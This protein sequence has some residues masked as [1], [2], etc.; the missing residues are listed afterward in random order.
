MPT[1]SIP[2]AV[3]AK[4]RCPFGLL[5]AVFC[6]LWASAFSVAKLAIAD[7]PPLL[8][9]TARF[10]LAGLVMLGAAAAYGLPLRQA[11]RDLFLFAALGVANQA[12]YL[13]LGYI[14]MR[15]MSSGLAALIISA[16]P[17]LAALGAALFLGERMSWQKVVGLLAGV[18]GV[19][20]V[21][22]NRLAGG[23][24][25]VAGIVFAIGALISLVAGTILFKRFAPSSGP[26][27][28]AWGSLWVGNGV[29][30]LAAGLATLPFAL[31]FERVG[32]IVATWSLLAAMAYLVLIVSVFA[33]LLWFH[34]LSVSGATAASSYHFLMPPL[35]LL[36]GWLLLGEPVAAA[37]LLGIV[38]VAFGIY[39][40]TRP[41]APAH[42]GP[43]AGAQGS[44]PPDPRPRRG[45]P[46]HGRRAPRL[47]AASP[48]RPAV[49]VGH[50]GRAGCR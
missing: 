29:Q 40:V 18:G 7:C 15:S 4:V 31:S 27:G 37:D 12:V 36:F 48:P 28:G 13:G 50:V 2:L 16:N 33:Y 19:A 39:L 10:L 21:V 43:L 14:G 22:Q 45:A 42:T 46:G 38:P 9:L 3:A 44:C 34:L 11:R 6:L 5:V 8:L 30:S 32:D 24:D 49:D 41:A 47:A 20:F 35:G 17:V 25:H 26:G 23:A 1:A